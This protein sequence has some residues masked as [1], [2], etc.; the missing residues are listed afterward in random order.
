MNDPAD[1][2]ERIF[3][4]VNAKP[5]KPNIADESIRGKVEFIC[6]CLSKL[7]FVS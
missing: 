7:L 4:Q 2:L 5:A 6:R 1:F 3:R